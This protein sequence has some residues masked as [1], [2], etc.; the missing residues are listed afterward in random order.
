M[1][2]VVLAG[3]SGAGKSTLIK[4]LMN[5]HPGVFGF[6]VSHTTRAPRA[7]EVDG[8]DYHFSTHD[9]MNALLAKDG[10]VEVAHV[11][12]NMYG[13]SFKAVE[14]VQKSGKTCILDIDIEGVK[15][16]KKAPSLSPVY[17]FVA[18]P[19]IDALEMRLKGRGTETDATLQTRLTNAKVEM[20]YMN[21]EGMFDHI[22]VN[23]V[24][25]EA[26][27]KF[28]KILMDATRS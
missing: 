8:K 7:G 21:Q 4:R 20:S 13:T 14:D 11:H 12:G 19:S 22:I 6:S 24:L 5:Q 26:Y 23:D 16:V 25:D 17:V 28:E 9:I 2:P 18:P 3:P 15:S 27:V 10:F 1:P